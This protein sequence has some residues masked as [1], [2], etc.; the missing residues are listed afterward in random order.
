MP[1]DLETLAALLGACPE[2]DRADKALSQA[3]DEGRN[4]VV[5]ARS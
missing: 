3:K 5:L 2:P 4:R 1:S